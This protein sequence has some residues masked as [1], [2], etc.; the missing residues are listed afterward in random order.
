MS[1][2]KINNE[3]HYQFLAEQRIDPIIRIKF[4]HGNEVV[5]CANCKTVYLEAVWNSQLSGAC[6]ACKSNL[7]LNK[8][9]ESKKMPENKLVAFKK[10]SY[11][12]NCGKKFADKDNY[13]INCGKGRNQL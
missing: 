13:C 2:I 4:E 8:L 5:V 12:T 10:N 7:L 3:K 1:I 11:C 6:D 9:P